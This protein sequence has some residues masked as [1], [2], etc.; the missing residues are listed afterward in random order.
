MLGGAGAVIPDR[1]DGGSREQ[2]LLELGQGMCVAAGELDS[3]PSVFGIEAT[4]ILAVGLSGALQIDGATADE[5]I[6]LSF[7]HLCPE[8]SG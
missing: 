6:A 8:H 5:F 4:D 3:G 7:E 1:P 2:A